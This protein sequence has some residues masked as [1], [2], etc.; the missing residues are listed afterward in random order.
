MA[1]DTVAV[2]PVEDGRLEEWVAL[3]NLAYPPFPTSADAVR[4]DDSLRPPGEP[5]LQLGAL[6]A[7]RLVGLARVRLSRGGSRLYDRA[8]ATVVVHPDARRE[9]IGRML[10]DRVEAF[11]RGSRVAALRIAV[12]EVDQHPAEMLMRS[13]FAIAERVEPSVQEPA[14]V[15]LSR[16]DRLRAHLADEGIETAAFSE[17]DSPAHRIELWR[18]VNA[19]EHDMPTE[20]D[21]EDAPFESF[22]REWFGHPGAIP[23]AIFVAR[24]GARIVGVSS[25]VQ[26]PDGDARV[27]DTGV[28]P[29]YRRRGI[30]RVLKLLA[31]R[32]AR[33]H[34][35]PRIHTDNNLINVGMLAL[36]RELG[37]RP[38][39]M[40]FIYEKRVV[41]GA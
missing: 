21:W 20:Q 11:A 9:G 39:P 31:T 24:D 29:S 12:M 3:L 26:R 7:E 40:Q 8:S 6:R 10:A 36:N 33:D 22:E 25:I 16:L 32:Y 41:E 13:N 17:I 35:I 30:A 14:S 19:V 15:D 2:H 1:G 38:G 18:T 37:F 23:A 34:G 4:L 5:W 28:L 27:E